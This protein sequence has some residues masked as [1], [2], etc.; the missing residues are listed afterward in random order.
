MHATTII[1]YLHM[2]ESLQKGK[3]RSLAKESHRLVG[4]NHRF[5]VMIL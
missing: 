2:Y 4:K 3:S 1:S 5:Q